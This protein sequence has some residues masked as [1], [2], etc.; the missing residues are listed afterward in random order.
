MQ[1]NQPDAREGRDP[2][3]SEAPAHEAPPVTRDAPLTTHGAVPSPLD[4]E[5]P[6]QRGDG[7]Q[8]AEGSLPPS[9]DADAV[10]YD[11][12]S[13]SPVRALRDAKEDQS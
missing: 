11:D 4:P 9:S 6:L 7:E 1:P 3:E 12:P 5:P 2:A 13:V 8:Q 10:G